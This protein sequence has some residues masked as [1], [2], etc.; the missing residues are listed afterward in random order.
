MP[1]ATDYN[2]TTNA[3]RMAAIKGE[4]EALEI[5]FAADLAECQGKVRSDIEADKQRVQAL[6]HILKT[7]ENQLN[8]LWTELGYLRTRT[9]D[10]AIPE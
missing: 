6:G 9:F 3:A 4:I 10:L 5:T 7:E 2:Q 1:Y 8:G